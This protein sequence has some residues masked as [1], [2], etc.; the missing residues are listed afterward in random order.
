MCSQGSCNARF[1]ALDDD[2]RDCVRELSE[3]YTAASIEMGELMMSR[4]PGS[5]RARGLVVSAVVMTVLLPVSVGH[6]TV[7]GKK[8]PVSFGAKLNRQSQ[9]SNAFDGQPC[10][11]KAVACTRVMT[12]AYRRPDPETDQRAPK[13]GTIGRIEIVGGLPGK[14]RLQIVKAKPGSQKAKLV[15]NGPVIHYKGQGTT[16][17]NGPPYTVESFPVKVQ[18]EKGDY[19]A[20]KATKVSFEYCSGGGGSQITFEPPL[21]SGQGYRHTA[22]TDGCLLLLEAVYK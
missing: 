9:P 17:D 1:V 14:F 15:R 7:A 5:R 19:L 3:L 22:H 10:E 6:A 2:A 20:V 12:E 4:R 8:K 18:V 21:T 13:N 16:E 11:P